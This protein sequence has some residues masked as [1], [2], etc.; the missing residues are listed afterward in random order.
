LSLCVDA[1]E[2]VSGGYYLAR[3]PEAGV[4]SASGCL[5]DFFPDSWAIEWSTDNSGHRSG[6]AA[7]FGIV[8]ES[9]REVQVWATES[10]E[11][12]FGAWSAFYSLEAAKN[13]RTRFL[14]EFP[15][16]VVFGLG[17]RESCV[18]G[19]EDAARPPAPKPGY[20]PFGETGVLQCVS[21]REAIAPGGVPAGFELVSTYLGQLT[22][23]WRCNA[24]EA[25]CARELGVQLNSAGLISSFEDATRCAEYV[26]RDDA[27]AEPGLWLPWL[28]T[29]YE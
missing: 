12:E 1:G 7:L 22:C 15:Q 13:A 19:F 29:I 9:L 4:L 10:F 8:P 27:G 28:I 23:S 3:R 2:Y 11:K 17:L 25:E 20:S 6:K 18:D 16:V 21:R 26:S 14:S 24:L 5:A